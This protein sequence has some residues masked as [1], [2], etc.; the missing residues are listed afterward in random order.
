M[1]VSHCSS[2]RFAIVLLYTRP[3][4]RADGPTHAQIS[5]PSIVAVV[6]IRF[7]VKLYLKLVLDILKVLR[8]ALTW[9]PL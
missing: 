7:K 8:Q 9:F 3:N 4:A 6:V 2:C 1:V 5:P